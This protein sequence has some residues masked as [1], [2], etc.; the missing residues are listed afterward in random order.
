MFVFGVLCLCLFV[1]FDVFVECVF[2]ASLENVLLFCPCVWFSFVCCCVG[3]LLLLL[4]L[5]LYVPYACV[6]VVVI[7]CYSFLV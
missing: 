3:C 1:C 6:V 5:L 7:V 4:C 2:L